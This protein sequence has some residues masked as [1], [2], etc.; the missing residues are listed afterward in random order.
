MAD[1]TM[2][3]R[4]KQFIESE[5]RSCSMDKLLVHGS[6]LMAIMVHGSWLKVNGYERR[7]DRYRPSGSDFGL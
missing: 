2:I 1:T 3:D 7:G 5:M 6:G 4:L